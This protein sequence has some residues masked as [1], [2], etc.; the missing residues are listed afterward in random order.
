[1][2][3]WR[4]V[5]HH[6]WYKL[7]TV[8]WP[9]LAAALLAALC[10]WWAWPT[11]QSG[12]AI[13]LLVEAPLWLAALLIAAAVVLRD[14][15]LSPTAFW[16]GKAIRP[17]ALVA[18]KCL[19]T[20]GVLGGSAL[21]LTAVTLVAYHTRAPLIA[22]LLPR[23]ALLLA[24]TLLFTMG[25]AAMA[26]SL[27]Q[28]PILVLTMWGLVAVV[29]LFRESRRMVLRELALPATLWIAGGLC[30]ALVLL[31]ALAYARRMSRGVGLGALLVLGGG[32]LVV[33]WSRPPQL[34]IP[35]DYPLSPDSVTLRIDAVQLTQRADASIDQ[36]L[37]GF[38]GPQVTVRVDGVPSDQ[39]VQ[40]WNVWA[41]FELTNGDSARS[42]IADPMV[43]RALPVE[44]ATMTWRGAVDT[45]Q[46]RV[47][48]R[49]QLTP[50]VRDVLVRHLS[51]DPAF[52]IRRIVLH[53]Y[54]RTS[55]YR[56]TLNMP[57]SD[58]GTAALPGQ[59]VAG[60]FMRDTTGVSFQVSRRIVRPIGSDRF[61]RLLDYDLD[62]PRG[63]LAVAFK[64]GE[65]EV[66][67]LR[68][69][70]SEASMDRVILP[71]V[72]L[73]QRSTQY[74]PPRELPMQA[75]DPWFVGTRLLLFAREPIRL[76]PVRVV[77]EMPPTGE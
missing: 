31:L 25:L 32:A 46:S 29:L 62:D 76:H 38:R 50:A 34:R 37:R 20:V 69:R 65:R 1:M 19:V 75:D 2:T 70:S 45:V 10:T 53:G 14:A 43:R 28:L 40:L 13:G 39:S 66:V 67:Q 6:M 41:S 3:W 57:Y 60:T 35:P 23:A 36:Q 22:T 48:V 49:P 8:R 9:L 73:Y 15:P 4:E 17:S 33:V 77:W 51:G 55:R 52:R 42:P 68:S 44:L 5:W 16:S 47:D 11:T 61:Y 12:S 24:V 7:R 64:A 72:P 26:R 56:R 21:L 63:A 59:R 18:A 58:T 27:W 74:R 54:V 30:V 71:F